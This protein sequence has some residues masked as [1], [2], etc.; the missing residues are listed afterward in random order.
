MQ[1]ESEQQRLIS[2]GIFTYNRPEG[3]KNTLEYITNQTYK[4]LEIIISD[5]CSP[6][7][8]VEKI[9]KEYAEKDNRIKYFKQN[10]NIGVV[11][12]FKFVLEKAS[13]EYFMWAADDDE[14]HPEFIEI[15][16]SKVKNK[17]SVF[18]GFK[19]LYRE[20]QKTEIF[21]M[22]DLSDKLSL[23]RRIINFLNAHSDIMFYGLHHRESILYF[24]KTKWDFDKVSYYFILKLLINNDFI[25]IPDKI[26]F[27]DGIEGT[28]YK[29]K[30]LKPQKGRLLEY[31]P[32]L[33]ECINLILWSKKLK[34]NEKLSIIKTLIKVVSMWFQLR[35]KD[36]RPNQVKL[37]KFITLILKRVFKIKELIILH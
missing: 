34:A 15:C 31:R 22:P 25:I 4:N 24:L 32:F 20:N 37:V 23:H 16:L 1:N 28:E 8:Q 33:S 11:Y 3:L 26:Y 19:S 21:K 6:D 17:E 13:G 30:P 29:C 5:N 10:K 35:E 12:N 18:T 9:A 36:Y 2:V 14:W 7:S 27:T